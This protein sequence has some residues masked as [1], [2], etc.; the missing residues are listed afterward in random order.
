[1]EVLLK[2]ILVFLFS[3]QGSAMTIHRPEVMVFKSPDQKRELRLPLKAPIEFLKEGEVLEWSKEGKY[4][5]SPSEV[6]FFPKIGRVILLGGLGDSSSMLGI[7]QIIKEDGKILKDLN[8]KTLIPKLEALA[9]EYG[10]FGNFPWIA[11]IKLE[12]SHSFVMD[13]CE[14]YWVKVDVKNLSLKKIKRKGD[15]KDTSATRLYNQKEKPKP[16]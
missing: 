14:K 2:T 12:G 1:M 13:I 16:K 10:M 11:G 8:V 4:T 7:I 9:G 3:Q 6:L 15:L 5:R